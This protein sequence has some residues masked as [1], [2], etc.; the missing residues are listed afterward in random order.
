MPKLILLSGPSCVGKSPL[1]KALK[2]LYPDIT[3]SMKKLVLF[4]DREIRPGEIDGV[5][6]HF[7]PR[8]EI[9]AMQ[10]QEGYIVIPVRKDLQAVR[11]ADI[12]EILQS[13]KDV[14]Y[15]GAPYV[16]NA[17]QKHPLMQKLHK[18]SVFLSPLSKEEIHFFKQPERHTDLEKLI[19]ELM[20]RKLLRRKQSQVGILG[21]TDLDDIETRCQTAYQELL[22]AHRFDYV[23]PNHDGEDSE[24]W[25][26]FAFPI[27]GARRTVITFAEILQENVPS[28]A[29]QWENDLLEN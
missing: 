7:R 25:F 10:E 5:D 8:N 4:N 24:H 29:E 13:G 27:G 23:I 21:Q 11:V 22:E 28:A 3:N 19:T 20:R 2:Q 14:F 17:I 9:E 6:Y 15:E 18:I 1:H 26:R 16:V 12:E